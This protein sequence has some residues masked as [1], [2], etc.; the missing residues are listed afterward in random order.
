MMETVAVSI[1]QR[2]VGESYSHEDSSRRGRSI[3][4]IISAFWPLLRILS[5]IAFNRTALYL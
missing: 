1:E 5:M 3:V 2:F 4:H